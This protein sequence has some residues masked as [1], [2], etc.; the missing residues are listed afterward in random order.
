[1]TLEEAIA[2]ASIVGTYRCNK[3]PEQRDSA[4]AKF[5]AH[6]VIDRDKGTWIRNSAVR[7]PSR[8]DAAFIRWVEDG[9]PIIEFTSDDKKRYG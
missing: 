9:C 7:S 2:V 1:M 3:T 4:G 8:A 6:D 5:V